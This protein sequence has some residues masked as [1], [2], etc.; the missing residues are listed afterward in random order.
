MVIKDDNQGQGVVV[1][2]AISDNLEKVITW[3][4][5]L[6]HLYGTEKILSRNISEKLQGEFDDSTIRDLTSVL[7][8]LGSLGAE[9][10]VFR[11]WEGCM[12]LPMW[13]RISQQLNSHNV[14][15][16][17]STYMDIAVSKS[18]KNPEYE[19]VDE[20]HPACFLAMHSVTYLL[21]EMVKE[22]KL[23]YVFEK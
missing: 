15:T 13:E 7:C 11:G 18:L 3:G 21:N 22:E 6:D 20:F 19:W 12:P 17:K 1:K 16:H 8:M 23:K 9:V 10:Y 4:S 14:I 2:N 5:H